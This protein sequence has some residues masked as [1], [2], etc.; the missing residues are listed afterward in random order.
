MQRGGVGVS[1]S[2]VVRADYRLSNLGGKKAGRASAKPDIAAAVGRSATMCGR[3]FWQRAPSCVRS[4]SCASVSLLGKRT[5]EYWS[6][7]LLKYPKSECV[8]RK[9]SNW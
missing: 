9:K 1:G 3:R 8:G 4:L 2:V 5:L 7:N 6:T